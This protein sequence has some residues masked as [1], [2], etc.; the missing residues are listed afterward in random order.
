[1]VVVVGGTADLSD[2]I[3]PGDDEWSHVGQPAYDEWLSAEFAGFV[4]AIAGDETTVMWFTIP[5]VNPPY[6]AGET[7]QPP[8]VESDPARTDRYNELIREYA[9]GDAR[10]EVVEFADAV[11]AHEGG[12]FEPSMRPDGAHIDLKHA[13]ELLAFI[14]AALRDVV[15]R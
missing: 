12:Q 5:D 2:R 11:K 14:D 10:V 1:V 3:L 4:D 8:F 9:A 15:S 13:P 6:I 7:G